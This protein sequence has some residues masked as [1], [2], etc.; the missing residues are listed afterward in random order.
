MPAASTTQRGLT[1]ALGRMSKSV[2]TPIRLTLLAI[3]IAAGSC[4]WKGHKGSVAYDQ[5]VAGDT[6]AEVLRRFGK[7]DYREPVGEPYTRYT[8]VPCS[9]P[10]QTRL[11]WED[12]SLPGLGAVSVE[13]DS[14]QRVLSK[15][16]WV[17]P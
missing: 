14:N 16:R 15:Y 2:V 8:S 6:E 17:S 10:C 11:W 7:P 9:P 4:A 1:Q 3:V 5:T 13:L 12:D